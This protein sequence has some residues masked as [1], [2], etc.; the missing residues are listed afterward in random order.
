MKA[1][2]LAWA[3][4]YHVKPSLTMDQWNFGN[5]LMGDLNEFCASLELTTQAVIEATGYPYSNIETSFNVTSGD[6][7]TFML[8]EEMDCK[9][10]DD[11]R[12]W[13][14][15]SIW[16][17]SGNLILYQAHLTDSNRKAVVKEIMVRTREHASGNVHCSGCDKL[18]AQKE[19]SRNRYFAGIYCN[20]CWEGKWKAIEAKET[21]N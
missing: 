9:N 6:K 4:R 16:A 18:V 15:I 20:D 10:P 17:D 5:A 1:K 7:Y 14:D 11:I 8:S 3:K 13:H 21:Y 2:A 19:V 12:R